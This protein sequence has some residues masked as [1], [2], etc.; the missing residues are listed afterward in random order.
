MILPSA[1]KRSNRH[2][3]VLLLG[4]GFFALPAFAQITTGSEAFGTATSDEK[5]RQF[6]Q[7]IRPQPDTARAGSQAVRDAQSVSPERLAQRAELLKKGELLLSRHKTTEALATFEQAALILHAA[8]SEMAIVR[9]HMQAGEYRRALAFGAHTAGAHLDVVGGSALYAWLLYAGGQTQVAQR[10][11]AEAQARSA[12]NT[13]IA[14]VSAQLATNQP[15]AFGSLLALPTRLAPYS[16]ASDIPKSA[17]VIG[18]ATLLPGGQSALV[19][20]AFLLSAKAGVWLRNGLGQTTK[21][22]VTQR[23]PALGLVVVKLSTTLPLPVDYTVAG[24]DAFAGSIGYA[25]EYAA[26]ST[27][28]AAWPVLR[29]GFL[30]GQADANDPAS[31]WR[32]L[33]FDMPKGSRG[34]PV[35]DASGQLTGI[36]LPRAAY[37]GQAKAAD[38]MVSVSALKTA[39]GASFTEQSSAMAAPQTAPP[40]KACMDRVYESALRSSLQVIR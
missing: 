8:D 19:P 35:F 23:L 9:S 5:L 2:L 20:S 37:K 12:S 15:L 36:A 4:V 38:L 28:E 27:S 3:A 11:L 17:R 6:M 18:S 32:A 16:E 13:L 40:L 30:G 10:L 22:T 34:G 14:A 25:V 21:A 24:R 29:S 39:L 1:W 26:S 33:G 31:S 7:Q